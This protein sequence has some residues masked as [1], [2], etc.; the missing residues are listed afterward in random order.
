[1]VGTTLKVPGTRRLVKELCYVTRGRRDGF[2]AW[3]NVDPKPT[4]TEFKDCWD[5]VVES[6]CDNLARLAALPPW[7]CDIGDDYLVSEE[8]YIKRQ[9]CRRQTT[10]QV[11]LRSNS[12]ADGSLKVQPEAEVKEIGATKATTALHNTQ[13][14]TSAIFEPLRMLSAL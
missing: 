2:T 13:L 8:E 3:I 12:S 7:D 4:G 14:H 6:K 9:E 11:C 10:L 5:L 1:M